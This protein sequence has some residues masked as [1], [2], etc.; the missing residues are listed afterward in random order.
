MSAIIT[1]S[2]VLCPIGRGSA[3]A[4]AS[5]RAGIARIVSSD[6]MDRHFESIQMGLVPPDALEPLAPDID[7]LPLPAR[8]RRMLQLAKPALQG[9]TVDASA[10][11]RLFL[12]TPRLSASEAPWLRHFPQYLQILTGVPI[13]LARSV[14]IPQGRAA[15]LLALEAALAALNGDPSSPVLVGGV[16]TFLDLKLLSMLGGEGRLLGP[17]VMDGFIPGEGAG[18][19][20][21]ASSGSGIA[22]EAVANCNDAGHRYGSAPARGE[23]L[24]E[25]LA[26]MRSRLPSPDNPVGV[27]FAGFNGEGFEAKLWGV[28]HLRH[29]DFFAPAMSLEHPADKYGDAGAA[30]G[31]LLSAMA[32]VALR[33]GSRAGPALIWAASDYEPRACALL[34]IAH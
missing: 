18:F 29:R 24:A 11:L 20:A 27:T 2:N 6:V 32:T 34:S 30:T 1:S 14:V 15:A 5:A 17:R 8:A 26:V 19:L 10:P 16:D 28:A 13:D 21:I 12:G 33:D 31:A 23:G 9:L 22:V 4:W 25:A 7:G 3:Q